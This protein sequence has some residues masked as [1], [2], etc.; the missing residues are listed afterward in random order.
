MPLCGR[1]FWENDYGPQI[2]C[3]ML[4][5]EGG[6][7]TGKFVKLTE[8]AYHVGRCKLSDLTRTITECT[9]GTNSKNFG[10]VGCDIG[11]EGGMYIDCGGGI[12]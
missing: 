10:R 8:D 12:S 6:V 3:K 11:S 2:F 7:V 1:Y 9:G 4:G 5:R